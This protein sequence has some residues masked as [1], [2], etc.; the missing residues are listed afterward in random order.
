MITDVSGDGSPD[1]LLLVDSLGIWRLF[2]WEMN[3]SLLPGFP[4][5]R[6]GEYIYQAPTLG[7]LNGDGSLDMT[8]A[9]QDIFNVFRPGKVHA[10][11]LD[12][13]LDPSTMHWPTHAHDY[14]RTSTWQPPTRVFGGSGR[15]FPKVI[16]QMMP[17]RRLT[18]LLFI[19][20]E[21]PTQD[22]HVTAIAGLRIPPEPV[23]Q[24]PL[25]PGIR[26]GSAV[27]GLSDPS[28]GE[29]VGAVAHLLQ[30]PQSIW[31]GAKPAFAG[32]ERSL[33]IGQVDGRAIVSRFQALRQQHPELL[34]TDNEICTWLETGEVPAI[35]RNEARPL[36]LTI[37]SP[38]VGI[39][40][41]QA[42]VAVHIVEGD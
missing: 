2:A 7:D 39:D 30:Q 22:L 14:Q 38:R 27:Q 1:I 12:V 29:V 26:G 16:R 11:T 32:R 28:N 21:A 10:L 3:G 23:R 20:R 36:W 8:L 18:L 35:P 4:V 6:D 24:R 33:L 25:P 19:P 42:H 15:V 17:L 40:K 31:P 9:E 41:L 5:S 34:L 13:P 37:E